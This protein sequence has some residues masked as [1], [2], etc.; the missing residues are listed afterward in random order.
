LP[1]IVF[2]TRRVRDVAWAVEPAARQW[3]E[4]IDGAGRGNL[5]LPEAVAWGRFAELFEF[6]ADRQRLRM[7]ETPTRPR[8]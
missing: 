3:A 7:G 5:L 1:L 2:H 6:D 8:P 4:A